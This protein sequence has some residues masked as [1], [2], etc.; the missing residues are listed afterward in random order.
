MLCIDCILRDKEFM[1]V[2]IKDLKVEKV[3]CTFFI[4]KFPLLNPGSH[5]IS[6]IELYVAYQICTFVACCAVLLQRHSAGG[7]GFACVRNT[8]PWPFLLSCCSFFLIAERLGFCSVSES[9]EGLKIGAVTWN[10]TWLMS[11]SEWQPKYSLEHVI[12]P[13]KQTWKLFLGK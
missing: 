4:V 13:I 1:E 9:W 7:R 6:T 8:H 10:L 3:F 5:L 11:T 12:K 2:F